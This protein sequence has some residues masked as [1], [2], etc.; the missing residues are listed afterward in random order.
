MMD[1]TD[2]FKN[3]LMEEEDALIEEM[4][5]EFQIRLQARIQKKIQAREAEM[6]EVKRLKKNG[7]SREACDPPTEAWR[8]SSPRAGAQWVKHG[9]K[10]P[11]P[12]QRNGVVRSVII[13]FIAA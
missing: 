1:E 13:R 9:W 12:W 3:E 8:S 2:D 4:K 10:K 11:P 5:A 6:P 7:R